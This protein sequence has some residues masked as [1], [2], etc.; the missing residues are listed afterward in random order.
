MGPSKAPSARNCCLGG[1]WFVS[2]GAI[3]NAVYSSI[4]GCKTSGNYKELCLISFFTTNHNRSRSDAPVFFAVQGKVETGALSDYLFKSFLGSE[5]SRSHSPESRATHFE[6]QRF[7]SD[8]CRR[9]SL[10]VMAASHIRRRRR[11]ILLRKTC[12]KKFSEALLLFDV[13]IY[14]EDALGP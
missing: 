5:S 11:D 13:I 14:F 9:R 7:V 1:D 8:Q 6:I 10:R 2:Q 4:I 12:P 3:C